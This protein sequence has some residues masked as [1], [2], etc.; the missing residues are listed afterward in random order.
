MSRVRRGRDR[1]SRRGPL[2]FAALPGPPR[3]LAKG[4]HPALAAHGTHADLTRPS[5]RAPFAPGPDAPSAH[6]QRTR[7]AVRSTRSRISRVG[8]SVWP[9]GR[10]PDPRRDARRRRHHRPKAALC[11]ASPGPLTHQARGHPTV[12]RSEPDRPRRYSP[13]SH[14]RRR[15]LGRRGCR[16]R[17]GTATPPRRPRPGRR[18]GRRPRSG[19]RGTGRSAG[20]GR[21]VRPVSVRHR[22]GGDLASTPAGLSSEPIGL[23]AEERGE[24]QADRRHRGDRRRP[25]VRGTPCAVRPLCSAAGSDGDRPA[26]SSEKNTPMDSTMPAFWNVA[27]MPDATPRSSAGHRVHHR[28]RVR[29]REQARADPVEAAAARRTPGS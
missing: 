2:R 14:P 20:R 21:K 23:R 24:H 17:R 27:R 12:F 26:T 19:R 1:R 18:R 11:S 5:D 13:S 7:P 16:R 22:R 29:C 4:Q 15:G 9:G 25:P 6:S 28:R 8:S 10:V 3:V